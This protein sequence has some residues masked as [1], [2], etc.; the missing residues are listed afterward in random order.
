MLY[1]S[2]LGASQLNEK[3]GIVRGEC[4]GGMQC[5][6]GAKGKATVVH[7]ATVLRPPSDIIVWSA[8]PKPNLAA[9]TGSHGIHCS[10]LSSRKH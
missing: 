2:D 3:T 7:V 1:L 5:N 10:C 4:S 9:S 6:L 8:V